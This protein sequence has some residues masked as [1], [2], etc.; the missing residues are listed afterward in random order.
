MNRLRRLTLS[1]ISLML[2]VQLSF[3]T[4]TFAAPPSAPQSA[5]QIERE[6]LR[7]IMDPAAD[8][9]AFRQELSDYLMEMEA[10][11]RLFSEI[12]VVRR[13]FKQSGLEPVAML[14]GA[15]QRLADL[16]PEELTLLR[17]TYAKFPGWREAPRVVS[18]FIKP[19][20]RERLESRIAAKN[21]G[22][23]QPYFVTAD[24]CA[25]GIAADPSNTDISAAEAAV[26]AAEAIQDAIPP[27]LNIPAVAATAIVKGIALSLV[28]LKAIKDDCT[29]LDATAVENIVNTA[30]TEIINNATTNTT[31]ITGAVTSAQTAIINNDNSNRTAITVAIAGAQTAINNNTTSTASA[32]TT[33]ITNVLTAVKNEIVTNDNSNKTMIVTN[34]NANATTINTNLTAAKNMIVANDNTNTTT[35]VNN[36]NANKTMIVNNDNANKTAIVANDNANKDLLL[37]AHIEADLAEADSAT[38]VAWYLTPTANGGHL[39][40]VQTIVTQTLANILAAGGSIGNAQSF[41]D[42]ANADKAAGNFKAA[43]ANYRKAYKAA[44]N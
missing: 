37:R 27:V 33:T 25:D 13:Q 35:I 23:I 41:L 11:L 22:D 6:R 24:N 34:D 29:G 16:K 20:L 38:P 43:Y 4:P 18:S 42:R 8:I 12:S 32:N 17:A 21:A 36:D 28:T 7:Q 10:A 2:I 31:T 39:D 15:R 19:D 1:L 30:K 26:I 14:A 40:L 9:E 44:A 5:K 3:V